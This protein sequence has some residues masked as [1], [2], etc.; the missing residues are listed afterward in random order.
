MNVLD[1]GQK[2]CEKIR[3]YL[4]S[5]LSNELLVETNH[6]VLRHMESC[7]ACTGELDSKIRARELLRGAVMGQRPA[8]GLE[9]RL[10]KAIRS[11]AAAGPAQ[12]GWQRWPIAAIVLIALAGSLAEGVHLRRNYAV[13][14]TALLMIGCNDHVH[15]A[16]G[17]HYPATPPTF[18]QMAA[19]MG[20]GFVQLVPVV[21]RKAAG[22]KVIEGHRCKANGRVYEHIILRGDAGLMSVVVTRKQPGEAFPRSLFGLHDGAIEN[23]EVSGFETHDYLVYV[24]SGLDRKK[25]LEIAYALAPGMRDVLNR[26]EA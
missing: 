7:P 14:E 17:G 25:N 10:R 16:L 11:R 9:D 5:Y 24:V 26:I 23:L 21:E 4:D 6:E 19:K 20:A 12:G 22:F 8:E 2:S 1:F 13:R 18:A 3:R 15:C